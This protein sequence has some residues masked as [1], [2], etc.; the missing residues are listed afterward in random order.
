M[1][2]GSW[3]AVLPW[4]LIGIHAALLPDGRILTFGSSALGDQGLHKIYDIWDPKTGVHITS[5]DAIATDEFCSAEVLDPITGNM[6]IVGGDG[7]PRQHQ[8]GYR[9]R[10]HV[11][12]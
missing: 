5:T 3:S 12:L 9:R 2:S 4:P 7:R 11:R 8:Q 1:N 10:Q 6:I